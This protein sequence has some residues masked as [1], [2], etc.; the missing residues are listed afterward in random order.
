[1]RRLLAVLFCGAALGQQGPPARVVVAEVVER[2]VAAERSFVGAV[3]PVRHTVV[4]SEV[5]GLVT[6][7]RAEEGQRVEAGAPLALLRTRVTEIALRAAQADLRLRQEELLELRNG[8]RSEEVTQARARLAAAEATRGLRQWRV[9]RA[10]QLFETSVI[11]EDE[12]KEA[13]MAADV[14]DEL[15]AE[16]RAGFALVETGP[17][18]ERIV[19]AEAR[20]EAQ[21]AE[22]AR[23]EDALERHTIRAP[24]AGWVVKEH[25]EV[26]SWLG[27]GTAV[28]EVVALDEVD[29]VAPVV[30]DYVHGV[31]VGQ[32]V[33]VTVGALPGRALEGE[34]VAL[35]PSA[36]PRARTFPVKVRLKNSREGDVPLLKAGMFA[37][38]HLPVGGAEMALLVP[39]DALVLGGPQPVVFVVGPESK[40]L[41]VPVET[42][43]AVDSLI[44][45]RGAL[46]KGQLV[47]VRGNERLR[48]D[49]AVQVE[50]H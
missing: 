36:D 30:E 14:A 4:E 11:S 37:T 25:T 15:L 1:M 26:G 3:E 10:Q 41:S 28:A 9:E 34:V 39:K 33:S 24:F 31:K 23:L 35:V 47:V 46:E 43:I 6:E 48:P 49:Q 22:V 27:K 7:Y 21:A 13:R 19:Q 45:V 17:R 8:S 20:V 16:A 5:E 2:E 12:L 38:L 44:Q 29:V 42:G 40:V 32:P 18:A 50:R